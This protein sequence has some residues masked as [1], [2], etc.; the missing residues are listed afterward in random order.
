M[1][2]DSFRAITRRALSINYRCP[3]ICE[4]VAESS[5][6]GSGG[7][8]TAT[9]D[10]DATFR[11]AG[12][13]ELNFSGTMLTWSAKSYILGYVVYYSAS[14]EGPFSILAS[15]VLDTHFD[16][17]GLL[18]PGAYFFK[19]TGLEPD[20]GETFPSPIAGPLTIT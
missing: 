9:L 6:S 15:N 12:P 1:D 2:F 5:G 19:V 16:V 10:I 4:L 7:S 20:A 14:V 13:A 8:V 11:K 18:D 3:L 17:V